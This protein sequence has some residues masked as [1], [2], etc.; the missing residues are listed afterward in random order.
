MSEGWKQHQLSGL[1]MGNRQ[2]SLGLMATDV[3]GLCVGI[4]FAGGRYV[5]LYPGR[6]WEARNEGRIRYGPVSKCMGKEIV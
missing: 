6:D 2:P 5:R 3:A 1:L 4:E